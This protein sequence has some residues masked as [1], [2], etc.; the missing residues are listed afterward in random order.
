VVY[1]SARTG[2][3]RHGGERERA[4]ELARRMAGGEAVLGVDPVTRFGGEYGFVFKRLPVQRVLM[5]D[6]VR[7]YVET[8]SG[9]I[10]ARIGPADALEG[11]AFAYAHKWDGLKHLVGADARDAIVALFALGNALTAALGLVLFT[12]G[13]PTLRKSA[14]SSGAASPG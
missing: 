4:I 2:A 10:A 7:Y 1:V 8:S 5:A 12:R 3:I 9:E 11:W 13:A 14:V 6:R